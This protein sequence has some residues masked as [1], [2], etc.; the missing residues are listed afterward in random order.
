MLDAAGLLGRV[1]VQG[2]SAVTGDPRA[3]RRYVVELGAADA[4][5]VYQQAIGARALLPAR[6]E[7][8]SRAQVRVR[9]RVG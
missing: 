8:A 1:S 2:A 5:R 4:R 9:V 3:K 7:G 6:P